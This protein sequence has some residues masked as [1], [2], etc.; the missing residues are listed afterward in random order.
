MDHA[1][2]DVPSV[3]KRLQHPVILGCGITAGVV[4][5]L[6][7]A[8]AV[9]LSIAPIPLDSVKPAAER[10]LASQVPG[11]VAKLGSAQLAWFPA[12]NSVGFHLTGVSLQ[13]AQNRPVLQA[14]SVDVGLALDA[15]AALGPAAGK[16]AAKDFFVAASVSP[17]GKYRLG[18]DATGVPRSSGGL[19]RVIGDLTGRPRPGRPLSYL[20]QVDLQRGVIALRQVNGPVA[21]RGQ[22]TSVTFAKTARDFKAAGDIAVGSARLTLQSQGGVGLA[23][24]KADARI[25]GLVP[26]RVFPS[27]GPSKTLWRLDAPVNG[28]A[29][30]AYDAKAGVQAADIDIAAGAG[31]V[32]IARAFEPLDAAGM[33]A[34]FQPNGQLVRLDSLRFKAERAA[35]DLTGWAKLTPKTATNP[36]AR[37][38][39]AVSAGDSRLA[40][41]SDRQAQPV[42]AFAASGVFRPDAETIDVSA[43]RL[44]LNGGEAHGAGSLSRARPGQSWGI[45][46][47][48]GTAGVVTMDQVL[49][50]WPRRLGTNARQWLIGQHT[51]GA[52]TRATYALD[53]PKGAI[54]DVPLQDRYVAVDFSFGRASTQLGDQLPGI[55]DGAGTGELRG[56]R[57]TLRV[58]RASM[59]GLA[60]SQGEVRIPKLKGDNRRV[61]VA[62]RARGPALNVMKVVDSPGVHVLTKNGIFPERISGMADGHVTLVRPLGLS[63]EV[64]FADYKITYDGTVRDAGVK[65]VAIGLDLKNGLLRV[66]GDQDSLNAT[67]P[68]LLGPYRGKVAFDADFKSGRPKTTRAVLD[69]VIDAAVLGLRGPDGATLPFHGQFRTVNGIGS[70]TIRS[71]AFNGQADWAST[72]RQHAVV[73]GQLNVAALRGVGAPISGQ[74]PSR[75]PARLILGKAG[76]AWAGALTADAYSGSVAFTS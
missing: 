29:S 52:V 43:I 12:A 62:L 18:Y 63:R 32:W 76:G 6:V 36:H 13:D 5:V 72:G 8:L 66:S 58:A 15:T 31:R 54:R 60:L 70:G 71:T 51:A 16:V 42:E 41:A 3:L 19:D 33:R 26:S 21:W 28:R 65:S 22:V 7:L 67:G 17:Q 25:T 4:A 24:A 1:K 53:L 64:T 47:Q 39:W 14:K 10:L 69:G 23:R 50:F 61:E 73:S 75:I 30:V 44:K 48:G 38:L 74:I 57:F 27:V 56:N 55:G 49:A 34:H 40:L 2:G 35:F 37:L 59:A 11:G 20:R 46:M 9:R 45:K 68:A